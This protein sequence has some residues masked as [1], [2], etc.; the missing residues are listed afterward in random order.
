MMV[1]GNKQGIKEYILDELGE[2]R[3]YSY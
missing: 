3:R 2:I 1:N